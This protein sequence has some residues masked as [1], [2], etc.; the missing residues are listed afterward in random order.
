MADGGA[1]RKPNPRALE[2]PTGR[3]E[4]LHVYVHT[5]AAQHNERLFFFSGYQYTVKHHF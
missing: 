3:E 5:R 4:A 1:G 2:V